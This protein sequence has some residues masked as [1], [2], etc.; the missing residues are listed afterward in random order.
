M[1]RYSTFLRRVFDDMS[2]LHPESNIDKT[3]MVKSA[4][5]CTWHPDDYFKGIR[6]LFFCHSLPTW[7]YPSAHLK[8]PPK[9][10]FT[11]LMQVPAM[12]DSEVVGCWISLSFY[13]EIVNSVQGALYLKLLTWNLEIM[14]FKYK[15]NTPIGIL[16]TVYHYD[17][18][19]KML[20]VSELFFLIRTLLLSYQTFSKISLQLCY[21]SYHNSSK[22]FNDFMRAFPLLF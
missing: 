6:F 10:V 8:C 11:L 14:T 7:S 2:H 18:L 19:L 22:I 4:M 15:W 16:I 21:S 13:V 5:T 17:S 20:V 9:L 1:I 12:L 3:N